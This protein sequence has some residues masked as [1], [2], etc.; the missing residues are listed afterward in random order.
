MGTTGLFLSRFATATPGLSRKPNIVLILAD[1]LGWD[2]VGY[3]GGAPRTPNI[4][5]IASEGL[6]LD[7]FYACPICSP[8]RASLLT[9]RYPIRDGLMRAVIPPWRKK[10]LPPAEETIAEMLGKGGYKHRACLGK[11]HLGHSDPKYHPLNQGFTYFYGC[12]NGAVDYFTHKRDGELD[13][14]RNFEPSYDEGYITDL[15]S[16]E[17]VRFI[18]QSKDDAPFFLYL[19]YTAPHVPKEAP[20]K[21]LEQY[22]ELKGDQKIHAAMVTAM[23]DGIG[24]IMRS[25]QENNIAEDTLVLFISDNG[26]AEHDGASND[27]LKGQKQ[28]VFEGGVR[29]PAVVWWPGHVQSGKTDFD[30]LMSIIDIYPTLKSLTGTMDPDGRDVDGKDL[31][32]IWEGKQTSLKRDVFMYWGQNS[33]EERLAMWRDNW[34]LVY[35]GPDVQD[36]SSGDANHLYLYDLS[37]DPNEKKDLASTHEAMVHAMLP[38]LKGFRKLRPD[39][40]IPPYGVGRK[41]FTAPEEWNIDLYGKQ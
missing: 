40:G 5:A 19:P 36:A 13:W 8:T 14:H 2:D 22:P 38:E 39:N 1:D 34:K 20:D 12:Y 15:L 41:G 9:G 18:E 4:D 7:R 33:N 29:V 26:G 16:D 23:D 31:S 17:A 10:G 24:R 6:Q 30:A 37:E 28:E 21:Y 35:I 27:P 32:A 3:H 25:I 11:W